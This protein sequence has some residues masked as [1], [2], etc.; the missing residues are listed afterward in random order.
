MYLLYADESGAIGDPAQQ[1]F[2]LAG[3]CA[4]E[5]QGWWISKELDK[6]ASRFNPADPGSVELHGSPMFAGRGSW[7][8]FDKAYRHKAIADALRVL[9][10]SHV[11]NRLFASVVRKSAVSPRDPVEVAFEQLAS[12]FD[13]YLIRLHNKKD[14]QRGLIVF[15]KTTYESTIQTL[16]TDFRTKGYTWGIIRNF[17]EVPLFLDS[18]ASRLIQLADLVAYATYRNFEKGDSTFYSL[19]EHRLDADGGVVHG[20]YL[21]Q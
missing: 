21:K 16:A 12:R 9:G 10:N 1:H 4:F 6:I 18:K 17:A 3:F 7:R 14:T 8:K 2:V 11:S 15:D 13:K 20:L 19:I 5:R